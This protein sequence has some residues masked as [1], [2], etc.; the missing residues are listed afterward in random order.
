MKISITM[1]NF[2]MLLLDMMTKEL[3]KHVDNINV[4]VGGEDTVFVNFSSDDI[5][6]VQVVAIICDKYRFGRGDNGSEILLGDEK[7]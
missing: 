5:V 7:P 6:K 2:P 3:A 4:Q 1:D